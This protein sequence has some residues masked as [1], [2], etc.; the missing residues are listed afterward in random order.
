MSTMTLKSMVEKLS[1]AA[2]Q[3][4]EAAAALSNSRSHFSVEIQHWLLAMCEGQTEDLMLVAE[5][6]GVDLDG[7]TSDLNRNLERAKTGNQQTPGLSPQ[8]VSLLSAAWMAATIE[9]DSGNIAPIH[10]IHALL[11]DDTLSFNTMHFL[12]HLESVD[13]AQLAQVWPT[14]SQNAEAAPAN[15]ASGSGK[16]PNLDQFTIDL[17]EQARSG[18]LD[19]ILGRDEEIR[20]MIDILTRRR[21][22][23]PI[24]TGEA[25][26]GK[27]AVVE[28]LAQRIADNDVPESL[29]NVKIHVL[30]LALLQAGAGMKGEFENRLKAVISEVKSSATPIVVFIDEAH[31][32]IGSGGQA[33]QNDAA[34]ILKPAL[35]RGELRTIAAT[36]WA[37]YKK[38]FEKDAALTRRFQVV[39]VEEPS[40]D[41][42]IVMLRGL[43]PV[44]EKH[45]RVAIS[46]QAL[47]AAVRLSSRYINGRQLPDKA[48]ALLDTACARVAM[49]QASTPAQVERLQ[50]K[51]QQLTAQIEQ[52]EREQLTGSEHQELLSQLNAELVD[53][54][55]AFEQAESTWRDEQGMVLQAKQ[56]S[57]AILNTE[58]QQE[59]DTREQLIE[60]KA[61]LA[62]VAQPMVFLE[63]D[64]VLVAEVIADW[65]GIPLG[66]MQ[67]DE[68]ETIL[69]LPQKMG[70][71]IVGQD[72]ALELISK[73][74]Q[75]A[76][77]QLSDERKPNGVFLLT[78]PSGT[79]K[80]ETALTLAEQVY[81]SED[82]L[83]VIN[84]S[85][86]KEEH[87]V[88]LLV[89]S[90]PGYVGY[91]E[92]G[93]LTEAVRRKPY[94]VVLLDEMEK[95]H[96]GVQD[97]FYQVF[98]KGTIKDGEGR[99][100]DFKN[101]IIIMTSN[102]GTE[103]T[104][105]LF[106]DEETAPDIEGLK[107]ALSDDLLAVFKPAFI[108]RLNLIPFVPLNRD[109]LN[110]IVRLQLSRV[111]QRFARNYQ[112][113][114]SFSE[115]VVEHLNAQSQNADVGARAIQ[116]NIQNELLPI[117][118]NVVLETISQRKDIQ[119]ISVDMVDDT[120]SVE[121][122]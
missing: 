21:Q 87:K 122:L 93:V 73:V 23:N 15:K 113:E 26:V 36:T 85:E 44:M 106:E 88:S 57:D 25:G 1:P 27:T 43:L 107:Q 45:H 31:T 79:G 34:N 53:T 103:T 84:M 7:L 77:A 51:Q 81:G 56:H 59:D 18:K 100:I 83:T 12:K 50:R 64:E 24:L 75:T 40:E 4:L 55:T 67:S 58:E 9:Y 70:E 49:S 99:D 101:T 6:F 5:H 62:E 63:V 14:L 28:G 114:L 111:E 16:T 78:G 120:Y 33:G 3:S 76:R 46:D 66:R 97:V 118:S 42:A 60:L 41:K 54:N 89:G 52:L 61:N 105:A 90:P 74:V 102:V 116:N 17:T 119:K 110:Q 30:D 65:T 22:N 11:N 2:K 98:D 104:T 48:V 96:P 19:P 20:Q 92:G 95:A 35:A 71:R 86:F 82:N 37:E 10:I 72:H 29:Q 8:I 108:G 80:T 109:T 32:L 13:P 38:Y 47:Q 69:S 68:V 94:S 121:M 91:G 39:K 112:A 115:D 117:I